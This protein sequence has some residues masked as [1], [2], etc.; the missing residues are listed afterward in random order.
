MLFNRPVGGRPLMTTRGQ[1]LSISFAGMAV[2]LL[3]LAA[4]IPAAAAAAM[5]A[6]RW[7]TYTNTR[8]GVM[9]DYPADVFA[10]EPPPP[11]N[12]GRNFEAPN[13][14]AR[15]HVYTHA[16]ALDQ[17]LQEI[18]DEDVTDLGDKDATKQNGGDWY[19]VLGVKDDEVI[20]HRVVLSEGGSMVHRLEIAF[21]AGAVANFAPIMD[22]MTKSFR[23]DP[24]I[25]EK[26]A[27]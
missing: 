20:V 22:R 18:E 8:Y 10:I 21:P 11:D 23:V 16:N 4:F 9:I 7:E 24:T 19:Q 27:E 26:A 12:A 1:Y 2:G 13:L 25:P 6:S 17:T 3:L 15:F 14:K 5:T